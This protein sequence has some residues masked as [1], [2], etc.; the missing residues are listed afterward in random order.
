MKR[1]RVSG[2]Q[3]VVETPVS[4]KTSRRFKALPDDEA[5]QRYVADSFFE[6]LHE[7]A[8]GN[9]SVAILLW[10][11]SISEIRDGSVVI[12]PELELEDAFIYH[13]PDRNLFTLVALLQHERLSAH[14]HASVFRQD[15]DAS[16]NEL[17]RLV[18][19]GYVACDDD[20]RYK[21]NHVLYRTVVRVLK[22]RNMIQ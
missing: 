21:L 10:L 11:G 8:D 1:H 22:T 16:L 9:V 18:N 20:G 2:Y 7:L 6:R 13:L 3:L 14:E 15:T 19:R 17:E 5:R 12:A 4:L